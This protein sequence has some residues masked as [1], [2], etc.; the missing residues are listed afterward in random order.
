MC[1]ELFAKFGPRL[2]LIFGGLLEM[3]LTLNFGRIIGFLIVGGWSLI[4]LVLFLLE[5]G[6]S[7]LLAMLPVMTGI[8]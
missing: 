1:G 3:V 7:L 2:I 8:S 6:T 4:S 5:R